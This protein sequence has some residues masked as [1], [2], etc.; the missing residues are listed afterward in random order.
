MTELVRKSDVQR[1]LTEA[2][3]S[4]GAD[5]PQLIVNLMECLKSFVPTFD[6]E[7]SVDEVAAAESV[8]AERIKKYV[9]NICS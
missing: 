5:D 4:G 8:A 7:L 3:T 1:M 2:F 6:K 9:T